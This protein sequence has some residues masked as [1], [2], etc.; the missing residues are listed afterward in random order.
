M[1][2]LLV[3]YDSLILNGKPDNEITFDG[4]KRR[5]QLEG[6]SSES[7]T[8]LKAGEAVEDEFDVATTADLSNGG[9]VLVHA[10]GLVALS[11]N[12]AVSG[13]LPYDSNKLHIE[14]DGMKASQVTKIICSLERRTKLSCGNAN[15]TTTLSAALR[16]TAVLANAAAVAAVFGSADK[17]Q[18][19][20]KTT[21]PSIRSVVGARLKAVA[22]EAS[23][24]TSGS[25]VYHCT[26]TWGYC[27]TNVLAYTIPTRNAIVNCGIYYSALPEITNRCHRQ[28]RA[29]TSLHE[30]T[31]APAV[32][33]P[34]TE[35]LGYGYGACM[36]LTTEQAVMNAD[37]YA[38]YANGKLGSLRHL[39]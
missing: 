27:E 22:A 4:I 29:T 19:Y 1:V 10:R 14:V 16:D 37:T 24:T 12:R 35:D 34:G 31:H 13:Y 38:L 18:E 28:D 39:D 17:F 9:S 8:T 2:C 3:I 20:F 7:L 15:L 11:E 25:T 6:L 30:F 33:N 26:D 36:G 21:S 23:S 5:I 32:Y